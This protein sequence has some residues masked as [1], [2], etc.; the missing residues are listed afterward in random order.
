MVSLS[1]HT[2]QEYGSQCPNAV[3]RSCRISCKSQWMI[4]GARYPRTIGPVA[5]PLHGV[6]EGFHMRVVLAVIGAIHA[7][8]ETMACEV[9]RI[10]APPYSTPLSEWK[11]QPGLGL[12]PVRARVKA[13]FVS[14]VVLSR[15]N[16]HPVS[17]E[18]TD[19]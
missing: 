16:D 14:S 13:C 1:F 17:C 4:P 7:D 11:M 8:T 10:R 3:Y 2:P 6:E 5:I 18:N 9:V 12:R 19:P 15:L